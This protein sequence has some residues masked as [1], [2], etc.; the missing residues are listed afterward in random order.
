MIESPLVPPTTIYL[1]GPMTGIESYN[2]P[3]FHRAAASLRS[4]G[5]TVLNPAE[6]DGGSQD[7]PWEFYMRRAI[8]LLVTADAVAVLPNW[9][10]SKGANI[11]VDLARKLSIPTVDAEKLLPISESVLAEAQR[12]V[13]GD[14]GANYGHP[15]MDYSCTGRMWSSVI[16]HWLNSHHPGLLTARL[17][18]IPAYIGCLMMGCMKISRAVKSPAHRDSLVDLAGY[19]E[20]A[21]MCVEFDGLNR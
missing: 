21:Q 11:E 4:K 14:R 13:H 1:A 5:F 2:F 17:P 18:D 16:E 19:T 20:C 7:K 12:L 15:A 8:A 6:T 9:R 3:A 10:D